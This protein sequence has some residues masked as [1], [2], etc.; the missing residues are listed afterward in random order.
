[1]RDSR[2]F[3]QRLAKRKT[4]YE[5]R[6]LSPFGHSWEVWDPEL[7]NFIEIASRTWARQGG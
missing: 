7:V 4:P 3:V 1:V 6:E 2:A 5:Y